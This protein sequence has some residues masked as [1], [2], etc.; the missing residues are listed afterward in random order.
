MTKD[1]KGCIIK[2]EIKKTTAATVAHIAS[3][4]VYNKGELIMYTYN[5]TEKSKSQQDFEAE[6]EK[7]FKK[8]I[9]KKRQ[10]RKVVKWL[11]EI[12]EEERANKIEDC[13]TFVGFYN[14]DG[15]PKIVKA[16]FCRE[17]LCSICAW[18]RQAKF[19]AQMIPVLTSLE[20]ED[21]KFIFSTVTVKNCDYNSLNDVLNNMLVGFAKLR[22]RRKIQRSWMGIC[23]S[24]ELTYNHKT[25]EYHPHIHML[26]AVKE[27]YF[28]NKDCYITQEELTEIWQNVCE[29]DYKPVCDIRRVN[30]TEK[31]TIETLKYA[32]KPSQ[33]IEGIKA[34]YY[35]LKG[36]RLISFTG[37]FAK[38]RKELKLLDFEENLLDDINKKQNPKT[39][40]VY[41]LDITGGLYKFY[42]TYVL[43]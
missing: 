6:K 4:T 7:I 39:Y 36:R 28:S 42:K 10:N 41:K 1:V 27:D 32:L 12:G 5:T 23:R 37:I 26:I 43:S 2:K 17:R 29:L 9:V 13:G 30:N 8:M 11:K 19:I 34:F 38:R 20:K 3:Q 15:I 21:Y 35:I 22:K 24:L 40:D 14:D 25:N 18:R 31:A 16:N 33:Y